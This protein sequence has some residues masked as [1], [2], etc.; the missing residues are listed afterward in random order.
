[1]TTW[2]STPPGGES[3]GDGV[4]ASSHVLGKQRAMSK[5]PGFD[6]ASRLYAEHAVLLEAMKASYR[7]HAA[8]FVEALE[9]EMDRLLQPTSLRA[10]RASGGSGGRYWWTGDLDHPERP[11]L[12]LQPEDPAHVSPTHLWLLVYAPGSAS[13]EQRAALREVGFGEGV[14]VNHPRRSGPLCDLTIAL[15]REDP[16]ADA[17]PRIAR[18]IRLL[19]DTF[20]AP[21]M[22]ASAP[23]RSRPA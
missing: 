13:P 20:D 4:V 2:Y 6:D 15:G 23:W 19:S 10:Y 21:G 18:A 3:D 7:G 12:W 17:A 5:F 22:V 8:L 16:V 11:H 9:E 14:V 1:M